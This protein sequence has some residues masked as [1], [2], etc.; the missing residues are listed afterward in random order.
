MST[1][2]LNAQTNYHAVEMEGQMRQTAVVS[3]YQMTMSK[4]QD[5]N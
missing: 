5:M 4:V 1:L 2:N 3:I